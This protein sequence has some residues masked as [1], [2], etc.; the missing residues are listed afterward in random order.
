MLDIKKQVKYYND[1]FKQTKYWVSTVDKKISTISTSYAQL[2]AYTNYFLLLE[3]INH[4]VEYSIHKKAIPL[5]F[6]NLERNKQINSLLRQDFSDSLLI[7]IT[8]ILTQ[9]LIVNNTVFRIAEDEFVILL[10]EFDNNAQLENISQRVIDSINESIQL[11]NNTINTKS[12]IGITIYSQDAG[13]SEQL[14]RNA[15]V[16]MYHAIESKRN[17]FQFFTEEMTLKAEEKSSKVLTIKEAVKNNEFINHYQPIVDVHTG[18]AIGFE[19]LMRWSGTGGLIAPDEFIPLSE[20]LGLII[21]MTESALDRGLAALKQ[22]NAVISNLYLSVN[23]TPKHFTHDTLVPYIEN[24]LALHELPA[25]LLRI[26]ITESTFIDE[27]EKVIKT[28]CAL[29]SLGIKLALDD[30]GTGFSSLSY[31]KQLPL[32]IIKIDR[33][34]I[35]GIGNIQSDEVIIDTILVLAKR[36]NM[37]CIAEGVETKEQ[38]DFLV[39][40]KCHYIQGYLYSKPLSAQEIMKKLM[41]NKDDLIVDSLY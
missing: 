41:L 13:G 9:A 20:E 36:L 18:K 21:G 31:L 35:S 16:A 27:P 28:M 8:K 37:Y 6:I 3:R 23:I 17:N 30:F 14:L 26:E 15:D 12:S 25:N 19:L 29:S 24:L 34:F 10:E 38:L 1:T 2:T 5:L 32:D 39:A 4:A 11:N 22:W 40:K 33:S 7:E